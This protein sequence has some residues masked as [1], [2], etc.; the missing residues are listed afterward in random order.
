MKMCMCQF[1]CLS[2]DVYV[3]Q[4]N[5]HFPAKVRQKE[6]DLA[7]NGEMHKQLQ[8][9]EWQLKAVCDNIHPPC[10]RTLVVGGA[11][12]MFDLSGTLAEAFGWSIAQYNYRSGQ[13][14]G[15]LVSGQVSGQVS[16][17]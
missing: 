8:C 9:R 13:V 4:S 10:F 7:R 2:V 14:S 11:H 5:S 6:L 15:L 17:G 1:V 3:C 16:G 12:T